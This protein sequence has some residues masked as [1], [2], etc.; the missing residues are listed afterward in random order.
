MSFLKDLF[1]NKPSDE[2]HKQFSRFSIGTFE[3]RSLIEITNSKKI[4]IKTS[5]EFA[6]ELVRFLAN[7]LKDKTLVSGIVFSTMDLRD[8]SKIE[9]E[10]VKNA[11]GVKKHIINKELTKEEILSLCGDFPSAAIHLSFETETDKLKIKPKAP[12]SGKA[13]KGDKE[14]KANFCS[15]TTT[16]KKM[17]DEYAFDIK[18]DFK[19]IFVKHIYEIEELITPDEYK[20]DFALARKYSKRKGKIKRI[21]NIDSNER[22]NE[23]KFEI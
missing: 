20:N 11:M 18:E 14:P 8:S 19:K 5:S 13:G 15:L 3:N 12:K 2:A 22:I 23:I 9:F 16:D 6:N 1:E 17:L 7:K 4:R 21:L 10:E